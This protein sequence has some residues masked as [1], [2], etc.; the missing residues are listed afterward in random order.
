[1]SENSEKWPG[2]TLSFAKNKLESRNYFHF[3]RFEVLEMTKY[4]KLGS[5]KIVEQ[6]F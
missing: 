4:S 1:M 5:W 6:F 3:V 2:M